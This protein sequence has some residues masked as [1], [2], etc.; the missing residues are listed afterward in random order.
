[1]QHISGLNYGDILNMPV[2]HRRYMLGLLTRTHE[3]RVESMENQPISGGKGV[4]TSTVS[5]DQLKNKINSG[6]IPNR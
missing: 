3:K 1:M 4:R 5:G 2:Y 6:Q